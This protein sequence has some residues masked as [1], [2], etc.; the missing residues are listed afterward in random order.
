MLQKDIEATS[1]KPTNEAQR[2][3]DH[4]TAMSDQIIEMIKS[5]E[6]DFEELEEK[7]AKFADIG[8]KFNTMLELGQEN[9]SFMTQG[10]T[11]QQGQYR[12]RLEELEEMLIMSDIGMETSIKIISNLR[13]RIKKEKRR[14]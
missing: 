4:V 8:R 10:Q 6:I 12:F 11:Q 7:I 2:R 14:C 13:Q 9:R 3:L 5:N 1:K